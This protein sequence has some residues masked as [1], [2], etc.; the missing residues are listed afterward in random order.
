MLSKEESTAKNVEE[1]MKSIYDKIGVEYHTHVTTI[2]NNGV[3]I[4]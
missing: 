2:N 3:K 4:V 1:I